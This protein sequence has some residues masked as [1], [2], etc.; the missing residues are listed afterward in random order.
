MAAPLV[1]EDIIAD[2]RKRTGLERFDSESFREGLDVL[3]TNFNQN[4]NLEAGVERTRND[5]AA[6]LANRLK[7]NAYLE[8]NPALLTREIKSP[9]FVFGIPRTGT[10]L[11]SNLLACDPARRSPLTWEI[12]DP[13]PPATTAT[14]KTDPRALGR[15]EQEKKMLAAM[16]EMGKYYRNSA[17]YP[18]ED[19][20][21]FTGDFKALAW[22][23]RGK[24]KDYR[25]WLFATDR[26]SAYTYHKR[27]LQALQANAPGVWN[28]KMPSHALYLDDLLEVYPDARLVWT[29]R[30]P[31][32][33][34]GSFCSL[35]KLGQ[36]QVRSEPDLAWIAENYPYQAQL[37]ADRIMDFREKHGEDR[38]IDV[39]YADLMR[40][41]IV[42][43]RKLYE[44]LGDDFTPEARRD[45]QAW[46][47]DNPQQKFGK[48]E[49][50][51]GEFGL[52]P[53]G[54]RKRF[55]RYLSKYKVEAEG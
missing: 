32:T 46:L 21:I 10:T 33:A 43:M 31:L 55:D 29:H 48:H 50:K 20:F 51:L 53:E 11:L 42:T 2:A 19:M 28:L 12:D 14:L 13:I 1:P 30:D 52:T 40:N 27:Y 24:L 49:Y 18:N 39:H 26:T 16:P 45:M 6:T 35:M 7:V 17:I 37:H 3:T 25:D 15:L 34:T 36:R 9:V 23:S 4:D 5:M 47:D 38:I 54:V 41:P 22:E 44:D 8:Q